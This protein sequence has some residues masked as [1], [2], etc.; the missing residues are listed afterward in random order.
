[1]TKLTHFLAAFSKV[2]SAASFGAGAVAVYEYGVNHDTIAL[3][4]VSAAVYILAA[5]LPNTARHEEV[6]E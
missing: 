3:L 2:F 5:L 4:A 1:M 6:T